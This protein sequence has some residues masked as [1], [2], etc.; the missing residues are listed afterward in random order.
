[1]CQH[2]LFAQKNHYRYIRSISS[3]CLVHMG[4]D[5]L[6]LPL[7]LTKISKDP[8]FSK[9][10]TLKLCLKMLV[11]FTHKFV[12]ISSSLTGPPKGPRKPAFT[13]GF[14]TNHAHKLPEIHVHAKLIQSRWVPD[15]KFTQSRNF[16]IQFPFSRFKICLI[17]PSR[18]P[19][20]API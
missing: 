8:L 15:W 12:A 16:S 6:I 1:M 7:M 2:I 5:G 4:T 3:F 17:T 20:G 14:F 10:A 9:R 18:V 19:L 11:I 13:L